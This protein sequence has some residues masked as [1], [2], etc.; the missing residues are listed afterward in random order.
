M[1]LLMYFRSRTL[2]FVQA[3]IDS[4]EQESLNLSL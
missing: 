3:R 1:Y 2:L 4:S